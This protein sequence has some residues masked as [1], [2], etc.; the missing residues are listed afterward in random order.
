MNLHIMPRTIFQNS[1]RLIVHYF[2]CIFYISIKKVMIRKQFLKNILPLSFSGSASV[3][4]R[5]KIKNI[6]QKCLGI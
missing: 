1:K 2:S 4:G 6:Y 3:S 5:E